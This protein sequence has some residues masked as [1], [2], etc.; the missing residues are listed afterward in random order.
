MSQ[1]EV[2]FSCELLRRA[3]AP[4]RDALTIRHRS[5]QLLS[6]AALIIAQGLN[7]TKQ[8]PSSNTGSTQRSKSRPPGGGCS[9]GDAGQGLNATKQVP[10]SDKGST[11]RS[12]SRPLNGG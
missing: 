1:L 10:S 6:R 4:Q 8:V 7:A 5:L 12:K 2:C 3:V 11:Q 9:C